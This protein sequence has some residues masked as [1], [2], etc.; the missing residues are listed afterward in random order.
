MSMNPTP[1]SELQREV[2]LLRTQLAEAI[3]DAECYKRAAYSILKKEVPYVPPTEEE[4]KDLMHGPRGRSILELIEE[5]EH[6]D[7]G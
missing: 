4:L 3:A 2:E 5:L 1:E 6:E 7:D